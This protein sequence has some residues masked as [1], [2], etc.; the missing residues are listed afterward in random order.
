MIQKTHYHENG[1][2]V[3]QT[4][5]DYFIRDYEKIE[6]FQHLFIPTLF[7]SSGVTDF[8]FNVSRYYHISATKLLGTKEEKHFFPSG[9]VSI[10]TSY[11]YNGDQVQP[12]S[13]SM[14]N[15]DGKTHTT[16]LHY[17]LS[18]GTHGFNSS[19]VETEMREKNMILPLETIKKVNGLVTGGQILEY[20]KESGNMLCV[21]KIYEVFDDPANPLLRNTNHYFQ[22]GIHKGLLSSVDLNFH[23]FSEQYTYYPEGPLKDLL[24]TRSYGNWVWDYDYFPITRQLRH[25]YDID[26]VRT[27]YEYDGFFRLTSVKERNGQLITK[28]DYTHAYDLAIN[29]GVNHIISSS[30]NDNIDRFNYFDGLGRSLE[31]VAH[32]YSPDQKDVIHQGIKYDTRGRPEWIYQPY[33]TESNVSGEYVPVGAFQHVGYDVVHYEHSPLSRE[34]GVRFHDFGEVNTVYNSGGSGIKNIVTGGNYGDNELFRT[35]QIDENGHATSIFTDKIGQV[36]LTRRYEG[37]ENIDT[38]NG[39]DDRGNLIEVMSPMS[40]SKGDVYSYS[41]AYDH[42]NRLETK[43]LPN[44]IVSEYTYFDHDGLKTSVENGQQLWY[45]YTD[46]LQNEVIYSEDPTLSGNTANETAFIRHVYDNT[47]GTKETGKITQTTTRNLHELSQELINRFEYDP[48]GRLTATKSDTP[49]GHQ[50]I[51][52]PTYDGPTDRLLFQVVHHQDVTTF[53]LNAYDHAKRLKEQYFNPGTGLEH[54]SSLTYNYKD[55]LIE[56]DLGI[57]ANGRALQSLDY[58]YNER[59]WL[60]KINHILPGQSDVTVDYCDPLPEVD[61][62]CENAPQISLD[63]LLKIRLTDEPLNINCYEACKFPPIEGM[64]WA[65][66]YTLRF[67]V[68]FYPRIH[69]IWIDGSVA[70]LPGYP[71]DVQVANGHYHYGPLA[72][73]LRAW[74]VQNAY[75]TDGVEIRFDDSGDCMVDFLIQ[76]TNVTSAGMMAGNIPGFNDYCTY[77]NGPIAQL[78][79]DLN[80]GYTNDPLADAYLWGVAGDSC[81]Y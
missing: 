20:A 21:K 17:P 24:D 14:V 39:Y 25:F 74:L 45:T 58:D 29:G 22:S 6:G 2:A 8:S 11:G 63:E 67:N 26:G 16:T 27:D 53:Q 4:T 43:R 50:E 66:D 70:S 37:G 35:D 1:Q 34:L 12:I 47:G 33:D 36:I 61:G 72:D 57:Q 40:A 23:H 32:L 3:Q 51:V 55:E 60:T 80:F 42:R 48:Y 56:K 28:H 9:E 75:Q 18:G 71:Y 38:Y 69:E 77:H 19:T 49:F 81:I 52:D 76:R 13:I 7:T 65:C 15:S 73:D 62:D 44:D 5:Y 64:A 59:G 31:S 46:Y 68:N 54:I 79:G 41:Y 78:P 10:A 30:G